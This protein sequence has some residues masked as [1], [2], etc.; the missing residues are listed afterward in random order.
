MSELRLYVALY[1]DADVN[2]SIVE[3]L[4]ARGYDAVHVADLGQAEWRDDERHLIYAAQ[5]NRAL[6]THNTKD[7]Q[8]LYDKWWEAGRAHA[9][10]SVA[11]H[12]DVGEMVKRLL[13]LLDTVT[14][15]EMVNNYKHL[16]E[17]E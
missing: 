12:W 7:F 10:I 16:G 2:K 13:K 11:P 3:Q 15:D 4:C 1:A 17:F 14:A 6:L 8:P 5:A 9:G